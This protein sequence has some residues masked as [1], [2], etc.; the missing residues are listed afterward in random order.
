[1]NES[2]TLSSRDFG[3]FYFCILPSCALLTV[4]LRVIKKKGLTALN[5]CKLGLHSIFSQENLMLKIWLNP[6]WD[7]LNHLLRNQMPRGLF[8]LM[9][10]TRRTTHIINEIQGKGH[11]EVK[12]G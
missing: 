12:H 5:F 11:P 8:C 3:L 1:M 4:H 7:K 9:D 2:L 10:T 6:S